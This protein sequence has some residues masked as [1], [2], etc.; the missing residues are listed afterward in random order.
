LLQ[1]N[2]PG[3][4]SSA[5]TTVESREIASSYNTIAAFFDAFPLPNARSYIAS[6]LKA[7]TSF[8][9]WKKSVPVDLIYFIEKLEELLS[10]AFTITGNGCKREKALLSKTTN[11]PDISQYNFYCGWQSGLE[12]WH[13]FPRHLSAQEYFDPYKGLKKVTVWEDEKKCKQELKTILHYAL[14]PVPMSETSIDMDVL[15]VH[16]LLHKLVEGMS[17]N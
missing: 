9:V 1:H 16:R 12:A 15:K 5:Q 14:G 17:F 13:F 2:K 10:A 3:K 6:S 4:M 7:A 8:K 11:I